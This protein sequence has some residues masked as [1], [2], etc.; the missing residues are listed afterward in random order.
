MGYFQLLNVV[1]I[2]R[3]PFFLT[4]YVAGLENQ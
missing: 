4:A 2:K 1:S 3:Q